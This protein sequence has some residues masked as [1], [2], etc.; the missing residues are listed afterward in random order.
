MGGGVG[1]CGSEGDGEVVWDEEGMWGEG[2][3]EVVW[4]EE[5]MWGW[6]DGEV[7]WD[8]CMGV[9]VTIG[10]GVR[11]FSWDYSLWKNSPNISIL[12]LFFHLW[13]APFQDTLV[14]TACEFCS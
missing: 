8:G 14:V 9:R 2:D 4:G 6:G 10:G 13:N 5:G 11:A 1:V 12:G 3:G 7:V